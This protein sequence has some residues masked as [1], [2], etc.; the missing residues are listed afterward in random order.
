MCGLSSY[1]RPSFRPKIALS[2]VPKSNDSNLYDFANDRVIFT[3]SSTSKTTSGKP[4]MQ[5]QHIDFIKFRCAITAW[6]PLAKRMLLRWA[7]GDEPKGETKV[8][9]RISR[10]P[11][12]TYHWDTSLGR[13]GSGCFGWCFAAQPGCRL[14]RT[15]SGSDSRTNYPSQREASQ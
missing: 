3:S 12:R 5:P 7:Q 8:Y 14:E 9:E 2:T 13:I 1:F 4:R 10:F 11:H 15:E 6:T